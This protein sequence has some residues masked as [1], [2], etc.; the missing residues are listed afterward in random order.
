[1]IFSLLLLLLLCLLPSSSSRTIPR[2]CRPKARIAPVFKD[3][4][5]YYCSLPGPP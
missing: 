5:D 4:Y 1:M 3:W 2:V